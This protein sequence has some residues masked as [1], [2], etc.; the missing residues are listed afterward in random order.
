MH[1]LPD[2]A[3][4]SAPQ[5][6]RLGSVVAVLA[7]VNI[8][9]LLLTTAGCGGGKATP[10]APVRAGTGGSSGSG[11]TGGKS[12]SSGTGGS[13]ASNLGGSGSGVAGSVGGEGGAGAGNPDATD[14]SG[15]DTGADA[16]PVDLGPPP[17]TCGNG[18]KDPGE[19][20]DKGAENEANPYGKDK[21]TKACK[22][23]PFCGDGTENKGAGQGEECDKGAANAD[24]AYGNKGD[25]SATCKL[26]PQCGD[27][28]VQDPE[29]CDEGED[30]EATP[31]KAGCKACQVVA[32][33]AVCG[34]GKREGSEACDNGNANIEGDYAA[35]PAMSPAVTCN[36]QCKVVTKFCG[37]GKTDSGRE[38][39]DKGPAGEP[40]MP[41]KPG[42]SPECRTIT[43][44]PQCGD[45]VKNV[46][47]EECDH[48]AKNRN[49]DAP[50]AGNEK[51]NPYIDPVTGKPALFCSRSCK[52]VHYCGDGSL[53]ALEECDLGQANDAS[54]YGE[55]KC[56]TGC[57]KAPYCGDNKV[58]A[59]EKCDSGPANI[60]P[61]TP[62]VAGA[63]DPNKPPCRRGLCTIVPFCG[64][65]AISNNEKCDN[66][67]TN[68]T[69]DYVG[70]TSPSGQ[71]P[72]CRAGTCVLVPYCGDGEV[73]NSEA[74]DPE[75]ADAKLK[76]NCTS[77]CKK[78]EAD[79]T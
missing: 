20:C 48:G 41:G 43:A 28:K 37:D 72:P 23:A 75:T 66:G 73:T 14:T 38:Q 27:K 21:C 55:G 68:V 50:Y 7:A 15:A 59:N 77:D 61:A 22:V 53:Q 74:C 2:E 39:C 47:S 5:R 52:D 12:S 30:K 1:S 51:P 26:V 3:V 19:D 71:K 13:Q 32:A 36:K 4:L 44:A 31:G 33:L 64:D 46:I 60:D 42:C 65:G 56:T 25:C 76:K 16:E 34:D 35:K 58:A 62:Y 45:G 17:V 69:T 24:K 29:R 79:G 9:L 49:N 54:A 8:G 11:G 18:T 10:P 57:A 70:G 40:A 78:I 67:K 6:S 63:T